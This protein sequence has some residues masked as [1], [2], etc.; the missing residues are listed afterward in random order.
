V[1]LTAAQK[2]YQTQ[3]ISIIQQ[4]LASNYSH[5]LTK[6]SY[7]DK[8]TNYFLQL[9]DYPEYHT[10]HN[11]IHLIEKIIPSLNKTVGSSKKQLE[12][13]DLGPGNGKKSAMVLSGLSTNSIN[14]KAF[15]ISKTMLNNAQKT[16]QTLLNIAAKKYYLCDFTNLKKLNKT[17]HPLTA[18]NTNM[19]IM[20]LGN[21]LANEPDMYVFLTNLKSLFTS[22]QSKETFLLIGIEL[23]SENSISIINQYDNNINR[24]LTFFPLKMLNINKDSGKIV[25]TLNKSRQRIEEKFIFTSNQQLNIGEKTINFQNGDELLLSVTN[26]PTLNTIKKISKKSGWHVHTIEQGKKQALIYLTLANEILPSTH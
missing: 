6:F 23:Y 22:L 16:H 17:L 18:N 8:G 24:D 14:Y 3:I 15:D 7:L 19:L 11:E 2:K 12:I 4:Q 5:T 10:Y 1:K 20:L 26:K 9:M 25:I 21:T 13:I